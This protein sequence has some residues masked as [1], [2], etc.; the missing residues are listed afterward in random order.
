M[1]SAILIQ[2]WCSYTALALQMG[3]KQSGFDYSSQTAMGG[4]QGKSHGSIKRKA[5]GA[6]G[7]VNVVNDGKEVFVNINNLFTSPLRVFFKKKQLT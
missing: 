6:R 7:P 2:I 5:A 3:N 4:V 1:K